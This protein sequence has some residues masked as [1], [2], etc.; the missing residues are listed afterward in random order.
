MKESSPPKNYTFCVEQPVDE[1]PL[2]PLNLDIYVCEDKEN[3]GPPVYPGHSIY[4]H[5]VYMGKSA[6]ADTGASVSMKLRADFSHIP[7]SRLNKERG[8][9]NR[10]YYKEYFEIEMTLSSA[11]LQFTLIH[12]GDRYQTIQV[13]FL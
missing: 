7:T 9:D 8:T 11:S 5:N 2:Q 13:E 3:M 10:L 1:G 4:P 12:K 6:N